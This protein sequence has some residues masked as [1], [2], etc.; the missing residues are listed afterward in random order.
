MTTPPPKIDPR[1]YAELV[2]QTEQLAQ[3]F[4]QWKSAADGSVDAG[5][6]LIRIFGR[7]AMMVTD[8]LNRVPEKHFLSFLNLIGVEQQPPRPAKVPLTAY[9][10]DNSPVDAMIP[11]HTQIAAVPQAGE[12][13]EVLFETVQDLV[14]MRSQLQA[15]IVRENQQYCNHVVSGTTAASD[16][17]VFTIEEPNTVYVAA[18]QLTTA[19]DS[20]EI[21][22]AIA[23]PAT[24]VEQWNWS[25]WN[26]KIWQVLTPTPETD[27]LKL[28]VSP[29]E[30]WQ[31]P[32]PKVI[33]GT[34][35]QW[36]RGIASKKLPELGNI[37]IADTAAQVLKA[38]PSGA[39]LRTLSSTAASPENG[40]YLCFDRPFPQQAIAL[41]LQVSPLSPGALQSSQPVA[42]PAKLQWEYA[43]TQ[44]WRSLVVQD[45]TQN[46]RQ[47]GMVEFIG[48][49]DLA[50]QSW[51]GQSGYWLRLR[52]VSGEFQIPPRFQRVLTNTVWATQAIT[53]QDEVLGSGTGDPGLV[54][55]TLHTPVLPGQQLV[56]REAELPSVEEQDAIRSLVG[57]DAI[58]ITL[59][60]AGQPQEIWVRWQEVSD[61]YGSGSRDRHYTL[62]RMT[63]E[64]R[65]G[66]A[67]Q[68]MAPLLGRNNIRMVRYQS[69]G[70]SRGNRPAATLTELRT[71]VPYVDRVT[72]L[73]PGAGGA[74]LESIAS[75]QESGPKRLRHGDRAVTWQDIEDL[76][77]AASSEVVRVRVIPPKFDPVELPWLTAADL[78][79]PLPTDLQQVLQ[80]AGRVTVLVVPHSDR[81]QPT[82]SL[83]LIEQ[84]STYLQQRIDPGLQLTIT[85]PA[86][87]KVTVT[88]TVVPSS[89]AAANGL[90]TLVQAT[91]S[92]FL[93]PLTGGQ[94]G[95]G[96]IFGRQPHESDLYACIERIAGVSY[97][98][99]L[100]INPPTPSSEHFLIYSGVH[101]IT[102]SP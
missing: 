44:G 58:A 77:Y 71:T 67:G 16:F 3:R 6:A 28:T 4:S 69:G 47:R 34:K 5:R 10:V 83:A 81:P 46:L 57:E 41:Y 79:K 91:I 17:P 2:A 55:R 35:A 37:R 26:G 86:W 13:E 22:L 39:L 94:R 84:I 60:D 72:N 76:T 92:R 9:L 38:L 7:M 42:Q 21:K 98:K 70:G 36:V 59:N 18:D 95:K 29:P 88:A 85:E 33:E 19:V 8:R 50:P 74:D 15:A 45:G 99:A 1:T 62:D 66:G 87:V 96:W 64:I 14:V 90:E 73:E 82:P 27:Q 23:N 30:D 43:S 80:Q 89:L 24:L 78:K 32:Q 11:A 25:Y 68:G 40:F 102:V 48:P 65:F 100:T 49:P 51:L 53:Y 54:L 20:K 52:K 101:R 93:H 56:V 75:V 61:F 63:G 31:P 12:T 97:V